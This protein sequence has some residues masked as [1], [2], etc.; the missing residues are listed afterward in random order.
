M[1]QFKVWARV[2]EVSTHRKGYVS[3]ILAGT[4]DHD[5]C[6]QKLYVKFDDGTASQMINLDLTPD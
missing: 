5:R 2:E 1:P 3:T 4:K 6:W